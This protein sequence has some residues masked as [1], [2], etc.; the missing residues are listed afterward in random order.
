MAEES[1]YSPQVVKKAQAIS[2][3]TPLLRSDRGRT[4]PLERPQSLKCWH[5]QRVLLDSSP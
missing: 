1:H 3:P 4:E 2:E 5:E